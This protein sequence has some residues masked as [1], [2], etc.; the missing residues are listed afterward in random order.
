M[1]SNLFRNTPD[2][3]LEFKEFLPEQGGGGFTLGN[4]AAAAESGHW[5]SSG[6]KRKEPSAPLVH[7]VPKRK[8]KVVKEEPAPKPVPP[9]QPKKTKYR[10]E[11]SPPYYENGHGASMSTPDDQLFFDRVKKALENRETYDEFLKLLNLFAQDIIDMRTLVEKAEYF[12]GDTGELFL[13]FRKLIGWD[14]RVVRE[15]DPPNNAGTKIVLPYSLPPAKED[16]HQMAGPSY[17]RLPANVS[18]PPAIMGCGFANLGYRRHRS[19]AQAAMSSADLCSM[20]S[21]FHTRLGPLRITAA[22]KHIRRTSTKKLCI[23][24]R[25]SDTNSTSILKRCPRPSLR[26]RTST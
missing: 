2:L 15:P 18:P 25:K 16:L 20:T 1:V 8:K 24:A 11:P 9:R 19:L 6:H 4:A 5:T 23:A 3:L 10:P 14:D 17:R 7:P 26:S 13:M 21:G 12:L 22:S